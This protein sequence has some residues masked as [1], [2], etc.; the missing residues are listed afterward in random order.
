MRPARAAGRSALTGATVILLVLL[1]TSFGG[2]PIASVLHEP[3]GE[4]VGFDGLR[5]R[6]L[7]GWAAAGTGDAGPWTFVRLTRGSGNFDVVVR[8]GGSPGGEG[9]AV[10]RYVGEVLRRGLSRLT[11]SEELEPVTTGSSLGGL[12]FRYTGVV[13]DTGQAIE[14]EVTVAI[15]PGGDAVAFDVWAP[16]GLLPFLLADADAMIDRAEVG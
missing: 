2:Y 5:V 6:P 7:L 1:A 3:A 13:S 9:A 11:V 12:R 15:G 4:P 10:I 16:T 8:P 14:G